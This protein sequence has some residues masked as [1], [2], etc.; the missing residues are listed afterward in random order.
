MNGI[1]RFLS[2]AQ[3]A[4]ADYAFN[5]FEDARGFSLIGEY[6]EGYKRQMGI[7][8]IDNIA[9]LINFILKKSQ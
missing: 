1:D 5:R 6:D 7:T 8:S 3:E 4:Y 2:A 9:P